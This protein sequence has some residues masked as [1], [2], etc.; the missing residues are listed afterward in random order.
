MKVGVVGRVPL[1]GEEFARL[2]A[3]LLAVERGADSQRFGAF[4]KKGKPISKKWLSVS[5]ALR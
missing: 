1:D 3:P 4:C 5:G 2:E